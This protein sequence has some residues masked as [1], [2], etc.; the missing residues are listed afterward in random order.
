VVF[1]PLLHFFLRLR[2]LG[3]VEPRVAGEIYGAGRKRESS[4]GGFDHFQYAQQQVFTYGEI[5]V[6]VGGEQVTGEIDAERMVLE[7]SKAYSRRLL[8]DFRVLV[9]HAADFGQDSA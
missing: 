8:L 2:R 4:A 3:K 6:V 7:A 9:K 1:A 5:L